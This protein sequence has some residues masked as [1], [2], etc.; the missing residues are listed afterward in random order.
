MD[1]GL[2]GRRLPRTT[3]HHLSHDDFLDLGWIHSGA[4]DRVAN[5]HGPKLGGGER[6]ETA[7][8][9]ADGS[10]DSRNDD[11]CGAIAHRVLIRFEFAAAKVCPKREFVT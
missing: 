4:G 1:L 3:L 10:A 2:S 11:W 8:I 5:D 9:A 6:G 7:Q